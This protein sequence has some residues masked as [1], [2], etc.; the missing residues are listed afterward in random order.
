MRVARREADS[1][2]LN[3][4]SFIRHNVH[5]RHPAI[6]L[7]HMLLAQTASRRDLAQVCVHA[8]RHEARHVRN[9]L[10]ADPVQA[11]QGGH[12]PPQR[13]RPPL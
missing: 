1:Y 13:W 6:V 3:R 8:C 5:R 9:R 7:R 11:A 2:D 12:R 4:P 10:R